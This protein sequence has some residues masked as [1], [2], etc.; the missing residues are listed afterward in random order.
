M[1]F[2]AYA[3]HH[4]AVGGIEQPGTVNGARFCSGDAAY[5]RPSIARV[6]ASIGLRCM[7]E[8]RS[9]AAKILGGKRGEC[10]DT[11]QSVW[12]STESVLRMGGRRMSPKGSSVRGWHASV[13]V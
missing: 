13:G 11:L 7:A 1:D 12:L 8:G 5:E 3:Y 10:F 2:D 4:V 9:E 6:R